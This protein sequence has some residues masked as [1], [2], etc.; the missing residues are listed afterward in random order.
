MTS[1]R[2][3]PPIEPACFDFSD[4]AQRKFDEQMRDLGATVFTGMS[5]VW[6]E[7]TASAI[8][9][10]LK[11]MLDHGHPPEHCESMTTHILYEITQ[12]ILEDLMA[13]RAG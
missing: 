9:N 4:T 5:A 1:L 12:T 7:Q 8:E 6:V 2:E 3:L 10:L 11:R 13:Q